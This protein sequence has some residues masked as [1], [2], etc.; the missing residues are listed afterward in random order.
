MK[1]SLPK[2][3][4]AEQARIE[5][6][7]LLGCAACA[8]IGIPNHHQIECHHM[9]SGNKRMGHRFT[10]P[11]CRGHHRNEFTLTQQLR[12]NIAQLSSIAGGRKLFNAAFGTERKLLEKVDFLLGLETP[13]P[14]SKILPRRAA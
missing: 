11:L 4:K 7:L 5:R 6:M 14:A 1:S 8:A 12:L 13:W 3:T 2:P 10:L 9:L